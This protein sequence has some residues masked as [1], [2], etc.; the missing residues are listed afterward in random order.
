MWLA[1]FAITIQNAGFM[2]QPDKCDAQVGASISAIGRGCRWILQIENCFVDTSRPGNC[3][4]LHIGRCLPG[5]LF[6]RFLPSHRYFNRSLAV[7]FQTI[8]L[9]DCRGIS[10]SPEEPFCRVIEHASNHGRQVGFGAHPPHPQR[11]RQTRPAQS[12]PH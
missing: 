5:C 2:L 4:G 8:V 7:F 10:L 6:P 12:P 9:P 3:E 1:V 11:F